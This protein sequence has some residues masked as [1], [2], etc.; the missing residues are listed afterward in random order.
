MKKFI[1]LIFK[2]I[3][4]GVGKIIPGV[5]GA[6][7][8]IFMG[9]YEKGLNIV[10]N[11]FKLKKKDLSFVVP[12]GIG[13]L[14]GIFL[15]SKIIVNLLEMYYLPIMLLFIGLIIG[16]MSDVKKNAN[17]KSIKNIIIFI[18]TLLCILP[19]SLIDQN[20]NSSY[21]SIMI[22]LMGFVEAVSMIVPGLSGTALL[23]AFGY[24]ETIML[25]FSNLNIN[26]LAPFVI[27]IGI[28]AVVVS[29]IIDYLFRNHR[30]KTNVAIYGLVVA[31]VLVMLI[32]TFTTEYKAVELVIGFI[33][34]IIGY[35]MTKLIE[36]K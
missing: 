36:K 14:I 35:N 3:I 1:I 9:V 21:N 15:F 12:I 4:I 2:G 23:M 6:M 10:S 33:L 19:L 7:L 17:M 27:G 28:G 26:V 11:I 20:N 13:I 25:A 22:V 32:Q 8:A 30:E 5:S 29:K 18:I 16:G 34:L 31:S 24:Y